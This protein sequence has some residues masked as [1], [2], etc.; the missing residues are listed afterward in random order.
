MKLFTIAALLLLSISFGSKLGFAEEQENGEKPAGQEQ[1][2]APAQEKAKSPEDKAKEDHS[3]NRVK[4]LLGSKSKLSGQFNLTY[5]GSTL[6]HPFSNKMPNPGNEVPPP[7]AYLSGTMAMRYRY[8]PHTT[9]GVGAGIR[10]EQPFQGPKNT[11]V[12][13]PYLDVVR[14]YTLGPI[15][16]RGLGQV[17]YFT[18]HSNHEIYGYRFAFTGLN[19]SFYEFDFGLTSGLL[20]ELDYYTYASDKPYKI[21]GQVTYDFV[22]APYFEYKLS[23]T[24]N[25]RTVIGIVINNM[26]SYNGMF[27]YQHP[28]P[29]QTLGVG[30]AVTKSFYL[31]PYIKAYPYSGNMHWNT[32]FVGFNAIVNVF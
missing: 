25:L 32:S 9:F 8:D 2:A 5:S 18:D 6:D 7:L 29:Y 21:S 31:Y 27:K 4:T 30:I 23:D 26:K 15:H 20:F 19:E 14:S 3:N 28:K 11:T 17:E 12:N 1:A 24:V 16:N 13:N 10:T 22:T